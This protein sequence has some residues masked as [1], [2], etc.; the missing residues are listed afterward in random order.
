[1]GPVLSRDLLSLA[2]T[3][4]MQVTLGSVGTGALGI[5]G[6][7]RGG[8]GRG[9]G[10][11]REG[12]WTRAGAGYVALQETLDYSWLF[13]QIQVE[14]FNCRPARPGVFNGN[15]KLMLKVCVK[16]KERERDLKT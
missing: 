8:G 11:G 6:A 16:K 1:M 3:V 15:F 13:T 14:M 2:R 9:D 10:R 7:A 12:G 4:N 5:P